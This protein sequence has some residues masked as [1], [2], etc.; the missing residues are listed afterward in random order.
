MAWPGQRAAQKLGEDRTR[1]GPLAHARTARQ[2]SDR[3]ISRVRLHGAP[4]R[5][6]AIL[7]F[8]LTLRGPSGGH[9]VELQGEA[10]MDDEALHTLGA[11]RAPSVPS[12]SLPESPTQWPPEGPRRV[13]AR[14]SK[15]PDHDDGWYYLLDMSISIL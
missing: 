5:Q 11:F 8:A 15:K 1:L 2:M 10:K 13:S 3:G 7:T 12:V 14:R 4:G 6:Q 9:C